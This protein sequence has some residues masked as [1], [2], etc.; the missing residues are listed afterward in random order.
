MTNSNE[1]TTT[2]TIETL[3]LETIV[4][5]TK[6]FTIYKQA[7]GKFRKEM[8][9]EKFFSKVP[10][11]EEEQLKLYQVF[12]SDEDSKLV[13]SLK[14]VEG[15]PIEIQN[16]YFNPYQSFDEETGKSTNGV[17]TMIED[18]EGEYYATSS[19]AVY[20]TLKNIFEAFGTPNTPNYKPIVVTVTGKKL[21]K[22]R[23]INLEMQ[24]VKK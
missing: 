13:T 8:K 6:D 1:L 4:S 24:G 5:D 14:T 22:G 7:D 16:V 12:N 20:F 9:Y 19:K 11:T 10:E 23:Q 21:A 3:A 15:M 2:N 17:T 18:T